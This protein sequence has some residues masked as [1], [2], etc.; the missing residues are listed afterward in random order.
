MQSSGYG[1]A[2]WFRSIWRRRHGGAGKIKHAAESVVDGGGEVL[3]EFALQHEAEAIGIE[4]LAGI[5]EC[6]GRD[7]GQKESAGSGNFA[8]A[9]E[10]G[11]AHAVGEGCYLSLVLAHSPRQAQFVMMSALHLGSETE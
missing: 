5:G 4:G 7:I 10:R 11:I 3:R 6:A 2:A 1:Y 9:E 8:G